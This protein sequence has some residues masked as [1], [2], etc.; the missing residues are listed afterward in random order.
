[1]RHVVPRPPSTCRWSIHV[2]WQNAIGD[3]LPE[4]SASGNGWSQG[5]LSDS[6]EVRLLGALRT[7]SFSDVTEAQLPVSVSKVVKA[8]QRSPSDLLLESLGFAIMGRSIELVISCLEKA[9]DQ[10]TDIGTIH[11][12]H[13]ATSC[14]DGGKTCCL[15]IDELCTFLRF[16]GRYRDCIT[17]EHGHTVLDNLFLSML[18]SH[19]NAPCQ[20]SMD[21][22]ANVPG[23][24][25]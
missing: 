19:S 13:I 8:A 25:G 17:N 7:N 1:M 10:M 21:L 6:V 4:D 24:P 15:I 16:E 22:L 11:P 5:S 3:A 20:L 14:L 12:L 9:R 18:R 23:M 2:G